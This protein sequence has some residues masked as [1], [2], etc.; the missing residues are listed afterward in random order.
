MK[1]EPTLFSELVKHLN[2][3]IGKEIDLLSFAELMIEKGLMIKSRGVIYMVTLKDYKSKLRRAGYLETKYRTH[4]VKL[5]KKIPTN[6]KVLEF[7]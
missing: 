7:Y 2:E 1:K 6:K 5:L 4:K 3:N